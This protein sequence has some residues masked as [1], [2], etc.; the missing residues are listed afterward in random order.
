MNPHP[1]EEPLLDEPFLA[2]LAVDIGAD[3]VV[4]AVR[5]FLQ[6]APARATR[7]QHSELALRR[8]AHALAG[9]AR[10]VGLARLGEAANMV[11]RTVESGAPANAARQHLEKLLADSVAAL[12]AW[13][14]TQ[15]AVS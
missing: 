2:E 4:E 13:L 5:I 10:A 3:G 14:A 12:D 8:E 11:Q 9:S 6:D 1:N 7:W 15:P